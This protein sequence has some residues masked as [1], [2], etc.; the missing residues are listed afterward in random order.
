MTTT[1]RACLLCM[2]LAAVAW[3]VPQVVEAAKPKM[4]EP[5]MRKMATHVI[6]GKIT[7]IYKKESETDK[8][9]ETRYVAEVKVE[10]VEKGTGLQVGG[11][12][13]VRYW[14]LEWIGEGFAPPDAE[15]HFSHNPRPK[16]R[17][18]MYLTKNTYD[19]A[20]ENNDG[21]LNV[22]F[23]DGFMTLPDAAAPVPPPG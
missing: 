11:L 3:F 6:V 5:D 19:G 10:K 23:Q 20:G 7:A 14:S 18:R 12:T 1:R 4:K 15:L 8:Q 2:A 17:L 22:I 13:Y 21:G 16:Q 9:K